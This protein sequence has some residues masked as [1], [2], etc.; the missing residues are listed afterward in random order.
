MAK[1]GRAHSRARSESADNGENS[2]GGASDN[3]EM[4]RAKPRVSAA[5]RDISGVIFEKNSGNSENRRRRPRCVRPLAPEGKVK[6][7]RF[8]AE[9]G[10]NAILHLGVAAVLPDVEDVF[11]V[12]E[13]ALVVPLLAPL[14]G[15]V[16]AHQVMVIGGVEAALGGWLVSERAADQH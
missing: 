16:R 14:S 5:E 2:G 10:G 15:S 1:R 7:C 9:A 12:D 3:S 8:P 6:A 13:V 4:F 11:R